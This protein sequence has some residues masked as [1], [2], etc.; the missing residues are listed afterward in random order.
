MCAAVCV[1]QLLGDPESDSLSD[2]SHSSVSFNDLG[3]SVSSSSNIPETL[4]LEFSRLLHTLH[5]VGML[6]F[7]FYI[8]W[9]LLLNSAGSISCSEHHRILL[10]ALAFTLLPAMTNERCVACIVIRNYMCCYHVYYLCCTFTSGQVSVA[11]GCASSQRR[12]ADIVSRWHLDTFD[13]SDTSHVNSSFANTVNVNIAVLCR[14][15]QADAMTLQVCVDPNSLET[16]LIVTCFICAISRVLFV[17]QQHQCIDVSIT[18]LLTEVV[19]RTVSPSPS[20]NTSFSERPESFG[21]LLCSLLRLLTL[22]L[23]LRP[24]WQ[25]ARQC[26]LLLKMQ[27]RIECCVLWVYMILRKKIYLHNLVVFFF[28]S[29][30]SQLRF[31]AECFAY[32]QPTIGSVGCFISNGIATFTQ[33]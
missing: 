14:L 13:I 21:R 6:K 18:L 22:L 27:V 20:S 28:A 26:C 33:H 17:F 15:Q 24:R 30:V 16:H 4:V 2:V 25:L 10:D 1:A 31:F 7:V 19:R 29:G 8:R 32:P 3:S 9:W 12:L 5:N 23:C 11:V